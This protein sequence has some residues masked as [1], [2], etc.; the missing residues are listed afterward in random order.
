[1]EAELEEARKTIE[2]LKTVEFVIQKI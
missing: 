2:L 1:M